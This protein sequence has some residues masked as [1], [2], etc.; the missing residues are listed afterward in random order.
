MKNSTNKTEKLS[1]TA[2]FIIIGMIIFMT[3]SNIFYNGFHNVDLSQNM[4]RVESY[5][6]VKF[7][8]ITNTFEKTDFITLMIIGGN[9][10]KSGFMLS[11][12]GVF[13]FGYGV[14]KIGNK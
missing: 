9:Q 10:I 3:G 8:E 14:N 6:D 2:L 13:L 12:L 7:T 1:K 11:M 4:L 5:Y